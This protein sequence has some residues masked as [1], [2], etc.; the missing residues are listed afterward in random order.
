MAS[1][2]A[3]GYLLGP[4]AE[5]REGYYTGAVACGEPPGV[6]YGAGA[7]ELGLTGEVDATVMEAVYSHV[8]DPR[9]PA[10]RDRTT[11]GEA[12]SLAAG[13]RAYRDVDAIHRDLLAAE[14]DAGPERRAELRRA[15][16]R[17]ARQAVMFID[18]TFSPAKSVTVLGVAFERAENDARAAAE[19][20]ERA[21]RAEQA[22]TAR[23][24]ADAWA[25]HRAAVERAVM[26][27][28]RAAIDYLQDR[29]GY[30]RVGHHGGGA[31]RWTDA[32]AFVV[33]QFLQHDSRD[34][35]PQL[36][37]HQAILNR[38]RCA[39][40]R[41]RTLDSRALHAHRGAAGA[42]G[43]RVME[44][45]LARDL[46]VRLETRPDGRARE[47]VGVP[48]AVMDLFSS[49]R[50]AITD[51]TAELIRA[52][53]QR[54]GRAPSALERSHIAQ[55]ATLA[56]RAAKQHGGES[57]DARLD[58]WE[59]E[60]RTA[61]AGGLAHVARAA[62][63]AGR[64]GP[65]GPGRFSPRDVIARAIARVSSD[66]QTWTRADLT[67]AVSDELPGHLGLDPARVGPLLESLTDRALV[68]AVVTKELEQTD[69]LTDEL[70]LADGRSAYQEPAG[71][72]YAAPDQIAAEHALAEAGI[73]RG[74]AALTEAEAADVA[75]RYA[76]HGRELGAD[77]AAA[78]R[79]VLTSGARV[80]V[81]AAAAGAGK[82]F[83]VGT[84]AE[85]WTEH[86][87]RALGLAPS[88]VAAQVLAEE[89]V[90]ALNLARWRGAQ[91]RLAT[92]RPTG[93]DEQYR[94]REGDLLVVDEAGMAA[95]P[96]LA[97]VVA[98]AGAAGAKVLLVGDARQLAAVGPGGALADVG[99]SAATYE[100]SQIRRFRAPWE[101]EASLRLRDADPA[102]L[103]QYDRHGRI[104]AAATPEQARDMAAR[105]WLADTLQGKESVLLV[106]SNEAAAAAAA[107]LRAELVR[108]G[109]V[110][111]DG[112]PLGRDGTVAGVGDRIQ[113]RR[114]G[115][116]LIGH[117]G[118]TRAP[119]NRDTYAVVGTLPDG[120]LRVR[121][122]AGVELI[123]P[124]RYVTEHVA[125][126]YASTVHGA[127]GRTVDTSH[128]IV[129]PGSDA[130]AIYVGLTRGRDG[131]TAW[132]ITQPLPG[133]APV[134]QAQDVHPRA[135]RAV[136]TE[137]LQRA[138]DQRGALAEAEHHRDVAE[139]TWTTVDRLA[140]G[141]GIATTGRTT[142]TLDLLVHAG[143]L[144]EHD[145]N[146]LAADR[147]MPAVDRLLRAGELAGHDPARVLHAAL[148]GRA[149]DGARAP[150]QVLHAR[151][152]EQLGDLAPTISSY[153]DLIPRDVTDRQRTH[154]TALADAADDRRRDLGARTADSA[155]AWA[156]AT[157]GPV[158]DDP[159]ARAS[160]EA[161]AGWAAAYRENAEHD[162]DQV[163]LGAA[164]PPGLA[165]KRAVWWTA[166]HA[167]GLP[168]V[169]PEEAAMSEGQLRARIAAAD[170]E[171]VWAPRWVADELAATAE[172]A[173]ARRADAA[174]WQARVD[175]GD[176]DE[177][178]AADAERARAEA[179]ALDARHVELAEVD[180]ARARWFAH[181]A[182]TRD[183][184][185]RSK[186]ALH[187]RGI[188]VDDPTDRVDGEEWLAEHHR[189]QAAEDP[190]RS[191]HP[192]DL[193]D[194]GDEQLLVDAADALETAVPDLRDTA[195]ADPS[196]HTDPGRHVPDPDPTT[197][198]V[199]RARAAL[200]EIAARHAADEAR[201]ADDRAAE[202]AGWA[203]AGEDEH[204]LDEAVDDDSRK[205]LT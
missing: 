126:A 151:I 161:R 96:D 4:V 21:G 134:G 65:G 61:L 40:G 11:W 162:D 49:R 76:A 138:E 170:R 166:H 123:L 95:T 201:S 41:W 12:A 117:D 78:V 91:Q 50:R 158:P 187:A 141:I 188:D 177:Q 153:R 100:L 1:G 152:R 142:A 25:A 29:A 14:P 150:G 13:P 93:D 121:D 149:L 94:I 115:W 83:V 144:T 135:A 104:R 184:A 114:N 68:G 74:A 101:G 73:A 156:T 173:A 164:P 137:V 129:G 185:E 98:R 143:D 89:G 139:S 70:R 159:L 24:E 195:T 55:Q 75:A 77:Q 102:A 45:H 54:H 189:A 111:H 174:V 175:A 79:G 203:T 15:A 105:A 90:P 178:L 22:A 124:A 92:G 16:E 33:A 146:A 31:G 155:P 39:D 51:R 125:L 172:Q 186:A 167:L 147:A 47:I 145:R 157:L 160:W 69:T 119:I 2:H 63:E 34:K 112:V 30:S 179:D 67:R 59:R 20:A 99:R 154:L 169:A 113:A 80:E 6:W 140:D 17:S 193:V 197:A 82:S 26:A 110:E 127:Q 163:A 118:N 35:D 165:E 10:S 3:V 37:V 109:R 18:A 190:H 122:G 116:D 88:Q 120:G 81:L 71:A 128:V 32:H 130:A 205:A 84:I 36:H 19:R 97:D 196:E 64:A 66:R 132:V 106:S 148:A 194:D 108:L 87:R 180:R 182:A 9:D 176:G 181:T 200:A 28:A 27:G 202:L 46:G 86:G 199:E 23:A 53:E 38:V 57:L 58:R 85:A 168:D 56:T 191:I 60:A 107:H 43:E 7:D 192:E 103:D 48:Q 42:H 8:L 204:D 136:V 171:R 5:A 62:L 131:N 198:A 44:A 72:R 133:D 52:Y 183:L